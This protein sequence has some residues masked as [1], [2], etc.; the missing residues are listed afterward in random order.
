MKHIKD[1]V[2]LA[3]DI[4]IKPQKIVIGFTQKGK[5][6]ADVLIL[7]SELKFWINLKTGKLDD[8]K[9]L[10]RDVSNV[11]TWGNG[12]YEVRVSDTTNLE[13]IMSLVKQALVF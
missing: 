7:K 5:V 11:G 10:T 9:K 12:D 4:E 1:T 3:A 13:Y 6:F 2:L 8:P